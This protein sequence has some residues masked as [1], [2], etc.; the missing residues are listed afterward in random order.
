MKKIL[1]SFFVVGLISMLGIPKFTFSQ[2]DRIFSCNS[3]PTSDPTLNSYVQNLISSNSNFDSRMRNIYDNLDSSDQKITSNYLKDKNVSLF[4]SYPQ[5]NDVELINHASSAKN[6][7]S[8]VWQRFM[9]LNT[10]ID[11]TQCFENIKGIISCASGKNKLQELGSLRMADDPCETQRRNC[12]V[13]VASEAAIM[14][15]GCASLD[16]TIIGGIICHGVA[17]A[18]QISAGSNCN[19]AARLCRGSSVPIN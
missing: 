6:A 13:A 1:K 14:H 5:F 3:F 17:F 16:L 11:S 12:I 4:D 7:Y 18:Y 15:L 9:E 8:L 19:V 2:D 10:G